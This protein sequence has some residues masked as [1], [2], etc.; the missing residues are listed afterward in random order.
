M[1]CEEMS[2]HLAMRHYGGVGNTAM[3]LIIHKKVGE[4]V[5]VGEPLVTMRVADRRESEAIAL[6]ENSYRMND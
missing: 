4:R 1:D 5:E 2:P 3:G 6:I